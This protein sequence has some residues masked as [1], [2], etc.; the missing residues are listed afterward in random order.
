MSSRD[1]P[2]RK[3]L[4]YQQT[5]QTV[6]VAFIIGLVLSSAQIVIDYFTE[7]AKLSKSI[8]NILETADSSA[9]HAAYNIDETGAQQI[10]QGL[11]SNIPIVEATIVDNFGAILGRA[12]NAN[13]TESTQLDKWVFGSSRV[14]TRPLNDPDVHAQSVGELRITI[15]P[16][17]IAES[18]LQR[19][20]VVFA[21]GI[22]RNTILALAIF[23]V[24]YLT[25]T[26]SILLATV[27]ILKGRDQMQLEMPDNHE[28]DEIGALIGTFNDHLAIID[29]QNAQ[30]R[31]HNAN[32]ESLVATRTEQLHERNQELDHERQLAIDASMAKSDFLAMMSHEI[33]TPMNGILGM[34]EL[35]DKKI[36]D[37]T[38]AEY[39]DAI[40]ESS[41][42]MLVLMNSVLDFSKYEQSQMKFE[43]NEF[44]LRRLVS[45]VVFL[46]SASA[47]KKQILL[48]ANIADRVPEALVGDPEK[49]R[50][51]LLNLITN[52]IKFTES[53][54]V[55][56]SIDLAGD[57]QTDSENQLPLH[58]AIEDTGIGIS[59]DEQTRIFEPYTQANDSVAPRYGGTGMGLAICKAIVEQQGGR[60]RCE[61]AKG[62]GSVFTFELPFRQQNDP[63]PA[64]E[65]IATATEALSPLR[66]L[67]ADD[68]KINRKLLQGQL[69]FDG[70]EVLLA[71]D[72]KN[73]LQTLEHEKVDVILLDLHMPGIDGIE[74]T[75]C[76]REG[77]N[78]GLPIIGITANVSPQKIDECLAAGMD[79]VINK[80]VDQNK[81]NKALRQVINQTRSDAQASLG[82]H[83]ETGHIDLDL[84]NQ[85]LESLGPDQFR[86]LYQEAQASAVRRTEQLLAHA[87]NDLERIKD[88]AHAIAGL[89]ANFG[90]AALA[91]RVESI[92]AACDQ[93]QFAEVSS[94]LNTLPDAVDESFDLFHEH[95][96]QARLD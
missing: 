57:V 22:V 4:A 71:E 40:I 42:S 56:L 77:D 6:I 36:K 49:L 10:T 50:Q 87:E 44:E 55:T 63:A 58:F 30:I 12:E 39:V 52:A 53:G 61:S 25:F 3:S 86:L 13:T 80:P 92:E 1:I 78:P 89:C 27:P 94:L 17:L 37:K 68:L 65:D 84:V 7:Q 51:V 5:K 11:V 83:A 90:L 28:E 88:G 85:H 48:S 31:E 76:I 33:R 18:F 79:L 15:D 16:S 93:E 2:I 24:F 64:R 60:I 54:T 67:V 35:L 74:T 19:A 70:H 29:K 41:K 46:L 47:E 26:R 45:G 14:I 38:A 81:L 73:A 91:A 72:G 23:A 32:L 69:E 59:E 8:T 75:H 96:P 21:S 66:V 20:G 34:A 43:N 95:F 82:K 9:F 62:N